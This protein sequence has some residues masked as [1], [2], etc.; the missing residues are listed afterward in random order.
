MKVN[1]INSLLNFKRG[2]YKE[3]EVSTTGKEQGYYMGDGTVETSY[4]PERYN[5]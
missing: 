5:H 3:I 4:M 2:I 1:F